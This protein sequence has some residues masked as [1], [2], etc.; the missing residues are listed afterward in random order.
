M[1]HPLHTSRCLTALLALA[2]CAP[3]FAA[4]EADDQPV[5][6][7]RLDVQSFRRDYVAPATS[8][9]LGVVADRMDTPLTLMSIPM[10]ILT[11]QQ[12]N[13]VEDALR[14]VAGVSKF[15]Q[16]NGGEEKF[17]VRGFDASQ[18]LY[19]DGAR[20]NNAFNATNIATTETANIERYDVLKG[21]AAILYGQG[22]PGGVINY[23]TK[24][25][26]FE[27]ALGSLELIAGSYDYS[28]AEFDATGPLTNSFA[29]RLVGSWED[30]DSYRD[31]HFRNRKLL[32]PSLSWRPTAATTL[33]AQ[34]EYITD[35]YTQD[36]GQV[37]EGDDLTGYFYSS[38]QDTEQFIGIPGWNDRTTSDFARAAVLVSHAFSASTKLE[39]NASAS[40]VDKLLYDSGTRT[41]FA[42]SGIVDAAGNLQM[43]PSGQ[44]G[45]GQSENITARVTSSRAGGQLFGADVAHQLLFGADYEHIDNDGKNYAATNLTTVTYNLLTRTYTGIPDGGYILGTAT[46]GVQTDLYQAGFVAQDLISF[47][48]RWHVL[49]GAR[50][51]RVDNRQTRGSDE[52]VSPRTGIVFRPN[53]ATA[54]YASWSR[55]FVPTTATGFNP[56]TGDGIGGPGLKPERTEQF[57][58]GG[59][60]TT[61]NEALVLNFAIFDLRKADIAYT[62][63]AAVTAF[64]TTSG[65]WWSANLGETRTRGVEL[66]AV[67]RLGSAV[68]L[69]AGYAY[70]DNEL[71]RVDPTF[72]GTRAGNVLPGIPL[73]SGN[74]W[75][76]YEAPTGALRGLGFGAGLFAQGD[77]FASTQNRARYGSWT[78]FDAVLYYK[79]DRWKV[80][81]NAKNLTDETYNL[82]QAGTTTDSFA[83]IRVGTSAPRTFAFSLAREF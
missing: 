28:R 60:W 42:N 44:G 82:A 75:A 59:R 50:Y 43:R 34:F 27:R 12:V 77:I 65:R 53:R 6:L 14:N 2:A 51:S 48:D 70:L 69:I 38:R 74:L 71:T 5:Q 55:G 73:H 35:R 23:V 54:L 25:P 79:R 11:D 13:N 68:R 62:D 46:P 1:S 16:G 81:L 72:V 7:E 21:P 15:K 49:A 45:R 80:Q 64:P 29:Y 33:T 30:S 41:P 20:I 57:E 76:V 67:G 40:R 24:K 37:L 17:S 56:A 63:P 36:R 8:T 31:A 18:S 10:D 22:E 61:A 39:L 9:G 3:A 83:A 58:L 66:Q 78:Q 32:A 47:G 19:K 4:A 26:R 52:D